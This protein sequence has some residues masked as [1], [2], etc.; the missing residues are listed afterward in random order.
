MIYFFS[1]SKLI[2]G[3]GLSLSSVIFLMVL[4]YYTNL[5]KLKSLLDNKKEILEKEINFISKG[6]AS[7]DS[8][9]E[10]INNNHPFSSDIDLYGQSSFFQYVNRTV[11][12]EAKRMLAS[13]LGANE[14][15]HIFQKQNAIQDLAS[16]PE[17][18]LNF[19]A[20][21][22]LVQQKINH[23]VI[24]DWLKNYK[25]I[26]PQYVYWLS[27]LIKALSLITL[28]LYIF[29]Y[30][31]YLPLA[32]VFFTGLFISSLFVKKINKTSIHL[33]ELKD[34]FGNYSDL[35]AHIENKTFDS[36]YCQNYKAKIK[37]DNIA[38][39]QLMK[40][41]TKYLSALDQRNNILF[42]VLGNGLFL[43][44]CTQVYKIEKWINEH[45]E[46]VRNWFETIVWF[47]SQNSLANYSYNHPEFTFPEIIDDPNLLIDARSLGH[48]ML[49]PKKRID[50]DFKIDRQN[51]TVVTGANMAGKSTFL[52][53]V[54]NSIV[55]AN[56]G[57]PVCAKH[58]KY[59][60]I[61]LITSMRNTDSLK[62][63]SSYFFAELSRLK[64]I[65]EAIKIEPYFIILDEILKGTNSKDKEQGSIQLMQKLSETSS[66]GLIATHDLG[67]CEIEK[68]LP[69]ITNQYFDAEIV[70]NELYFDY[71][72]KNGICQNM[73]ASFLL[74]KMEII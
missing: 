64:M 32:A 50:N 41:F 29:D 72:L 60:P 37:S 15:G 53:T 38:A 16:D 10:F 63:D 28:G 6:Q 30:V 62:D 73:N 3:I 65:I 43:W 26:I 25:A 61:K 54:S 9:S 56:I 19:S 12:S 13:I 20:K 34:T 58:F 40:Q 5:K 35:I 31:G 51:F 47:D 69:N 74:K 8:G 46:N 4:S 59:N 57:L 11:I 24:F 66:S 48:F 55:S 21:S 2:L 49:D 33:S 17:W 42:A 71:T 39:S 22:T 23:S 45:K 52:R 1:D 14:T 7:F 36:D 27:F 70:D 68:S 67:L 18:R 44:D